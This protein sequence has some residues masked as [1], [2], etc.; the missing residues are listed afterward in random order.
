MD[1]SLFIPEDEISDSDLD[2]NDEEPLLDEFSDEVSEPESID[3][4]DE[5]QKV[6]VDRAPH[7]FD[8]AENTQAAMPVNLS[9]YDS[10]SLFIDDYVTNMI[11]V[12]TNRLALYLQILRRG[13]GMQNYV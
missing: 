4:C 1:N 3:L 11:V 13:G 10:F 7:R 8:F 6:S 2:L 5:W 9:V 12:E